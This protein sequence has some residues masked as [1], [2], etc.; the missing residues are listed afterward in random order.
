[1]ARRNEG[2]K[3][4]APR[5]ACGSYTVR[6]RWAGS[7]YERSTGHTDAE[8]AAGEAARI[9]ARVVATTPREG[10]RR[11]GTAELSGV[12]AQWLTSLAATHDPA[13]VAGYLGY[14]ESQWVPRFRTLAGITTAHVEAYAAERLATVRASTVRKELSAL[15]GFVAWAAAR[16]LMPPVPIPG[17]PK[18]TVGT[19]YAKRRRSAAIPLTVAEVEALLAALPEWTR[20]RP[21]YPVRARFVV[22]YETGLRPELLDL[23]SVPEH[24]EPG[25]DSITITPELDK[26]RW[27]R[28][29]PLSPRAQRALESVCPADGVIF[30][31]HDYRAH[32]RAAA[33]K[34]L[35][36]ERAKVFTGAHLRS[37]RATHWLD[38]GA[39]LTGVQYLLGHR[40]LET[41]ARYV[42]AAESA[43]AAI[44]RP[45]RKR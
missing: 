28:T 5:G 15:R 24:Y 22:G 40:R 45:R 37:A 21:R 2:W 11:R 34:A 18:R 13:T 10:R 8:R 25:A 4:R 36:P 20:R 19:S 39:P 42:R 44:V 38:A 41:T 26:G 12:V 29:V 23:L 1:M 16:H 14:S 27:S 30:G 6:F 32:L 3:L 7:D 35:P 31:R 9:Y 17:L 33:S 43:A